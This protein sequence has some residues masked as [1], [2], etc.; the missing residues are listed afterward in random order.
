MERLCTGNARVNRLST[1]AQAADCL[2]KAA[3]TLSEA[4]RAAAESFSSELLDIP[5]VFNSLSEE[6]TPGSGLNS[7][8]RGDEEWADPEETNNYIYLSGWPSDEQRYEEQRLIHQAQN[9]I[10]VACSEDEELYPAGAAVMWQSQPWPGDV[11]SFRVSVAL[12]RP[13]F[14]KK[15]ALLPAEM[16]AKVYPDWISCHGPRGH[17][18][19][20]FWDPITLVKRANSFLLDVLKYNPPGSKNSG[21]GPQ[22]FLPAVSEGFVAHNGLELAV[23]EGVLRVKPADSGLNHVS[24]LPTNDWT[25][26]DV[27]DWASEPASAN[28]F[29]STPGETYFALDEEFDAIPLI[30][31]LATTCAPSLRKVVLFVN[32]TGCRSQYRTLI[33]R[34]TDWRVFA[35]ENEENGPSNKEVMSDFVQSREP[36]I[37]ILHIRVRTLS[38]LENV[39]L[40]YCIYW[41]S[42]LSTNGGTAPFV[43]AKRH[44]TALKCESTSIITTTAQAS[45]KSE[46]FSS[47]EHPNCADLLEG[48]DSSW[49]SD[50]RTT[51]RL[52]LSGDPQVAKSLYEN[53]LKAIGKNC[54]HLEAEE[55][56]GRI[57]KFTANVLL[58]GEAEDG[59][60]KYPP[61]AGRPTTPSSIVDELNLQA[62]VDA[63]LLPAMGYYRNISSMLPKDCHENQAILLS[64]AT[65]CLSKAA[66]A[67]SEA[68]EAM[69]A[70]AKSF[71]P[72]I[73][74]AVPVSQPLTNTETNNGI[75]AI[76]DYESDSDSSPT[77]E[78]LP[79]PA[80]P[81]NN[82]QGQRNDSEFTTDITG[83]GSALT[84]KEHLAT[85]SSGL[86]TR[87]NADT[88]PPTTTNKPLETAET[89]LL[90]PSYRILLDDEADVLLAACS[91]IR[92]GR[93]II[94]YVRSSITALDVYE[95]VLS[96][97]RVPVHR[98]KSSSSQEH[99]RLV[100]AFQHGPSS[101]L[102][103][104]ATHA[105]AFKIDEPDSW[106]IHVGWP[107]NEDLYKQQIT[108]HQ[109]K[110]NV[111][112]AYSEDKDIYP[113]SS[114]I[115]TYA[116]PWP[117]GELL[118]KEAC[119]NLRPTFNK[120]LAEIPA[121]TKA[122]VYTDWI[123]HHGLRGPY[124][125]PSWSAS[126]LVYRANL[127]LLN[128]FKYNAGASDISPGTQTA[129]P[130][131]SAGFVTS[132]S[133]QSA[134]QEGILQ[135]KP[136]SGNNH[137]SSLPHDA[138]PAGTIS[139]NEAE[140][141]KSFSNPSSTTGPA[142]GSYYK[143][144][145]I[146][147]NPTPQPDATWGGWNPSSQ[148]H[149]PTRSTS[150]VGSIADVETNRS[151]SRQENIRL[152]PHVK[153]YLIIEADLDL[154]PA[155]C[156]LSNR[157]NSK[158]VI[159][160]LKDLN[161]FVPLA[162]LIEQMVAKPVFFANANFIL[163]E[164]TR[165]ALNSPIGC[166]I[167]CNLY[168]GVPTGLQN[169]HID[170][171]IHI[172]WVD[173]PAIY[174]NQIQQIS[175]TVVL[176][177]SELQGPNGPEL[178]ASLNRVGV[179]PMSAATKRL[180]SQRTTTSILEPGR[181]LWKE[182]L[183]SS[184]SVSSIRASY[185]GWLSQHYQGPNK[186][187]GWT[188]VDVAMHANR[189][190]KGL[191]NCGN[192]GGAFQGRPSVTE[193]FV[194]HIGLEAAV[195]A[196]LLTVRG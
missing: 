149:T 40:G 41:G 184:I 151:T 161:A 102:L 16:K 104:P 158:N 134:V 58:M 156:H 176:L 66:I 181:K 165:I 37:L 61:I 127:Y 179:R 78:N 63:G 117:H 45:K 122:K 47:R 92:K 4:A 80:N 34:I 138:V 182:L 93:K 111:F 33:E 30:C 35:F 84:D 55:I 115:L 148:S 43:K 50:M 12:L 162:K 74:S 44:Q 90:P 42:T 174:H 21:S 105:P 187:Q 75:N 178:M 27:L 91:L 150:R 87:T 145:S 23:S 109:A 6:E 18:H 170:M 10:I 190:F 144:P 99:E 141:S 26:P 120:K 143:A 101:V 106:V 39:S 100:E 188:A 56:A 79:T 186:E 169:V 107:T 130:T 71:I 60:K 57:N 82:A 59:S 157:A 69:A 65:E 112:V 103:L 133:L 113:C 25:E 81:T 96:A 135:V 62:A 146:A 185:M 94:F 137:I 88:Q 173:S 38:P 95:A 154:F 73:T 98:I 77:T 67:L 152:P 195:A 13:V 20:G 121:K 125:P 17:R 86:G 36:A 131:V 163:A 97:T 123:T 24:S 3:I 175:N 9:G 64:H 189:Y 116:Q 171:T 140:S 114:S 118:L 54:S 46:G 49:L 155:I 53:H 85:Q 11:D 167:L 124:H 68:A 31:F 22:I 28:N 5:A 183:T 139:L 177:R 108:Y 168:S 76:V 129:L 48:R 1:L 193:R 7:N 160:F 136:S 132:Q 72:G 172:G 14:D 83:K 8:E 52:V 180:Y 89:Q 15:L 19:V 196:G 2:A 192:D 110:N 147:L 70:A 29:E 142:G 159:W 119:T 194:K 128:V 126:T 32:F 164:S 166:V 51:V 191:F 153:E